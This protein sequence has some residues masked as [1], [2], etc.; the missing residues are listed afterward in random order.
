MIFKH[1]FVLNQLTIIY[2][3][4]SVSLDATTFGFF[5]EQELVSGNSLGHAEQFFHVTFLPLH[6]VHVLTERLRQ[7]VQR[8]FGEELRT[9]LVDVAGSVSQNTLNKAQSQVPLY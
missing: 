3:G 5:V 8:L 7:L 4:T 9:V 6:L 1:D 2:V